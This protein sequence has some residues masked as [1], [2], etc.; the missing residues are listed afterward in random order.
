VTESASLWAYFLLSLGIVALPGMDMAFVLASTL[1]AGRR[2]ALAALAGIVSGG[3]V[4]IVL[5]GLGL[6]LLL[7]AEPGL[8]RGLALAGAAYMAWIG[9]G[10]LREAEAPVHGAA[11]PPAAPVRVFL[12]GLMT[13]LLNPKAYLF[14]AAVLPQFIHPGRGP[15][16]AQAAALAMITA[17][18]QIAVYGTVAAGALRTGDGLHPGGR[19]HIWLGRTVGGM[20][21][22]MAGGAAWQAFTLGGP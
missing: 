8:L 18:V 3:L 6:G 5:G 13:C 17:A 2:G 7:T 20:M 15:L 4:H 12:R 9:W 16:L 19:G 22:L 14:V 21:L 1:R 11:A 10:V